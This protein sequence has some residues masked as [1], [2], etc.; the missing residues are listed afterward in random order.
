MLKFVQPSIM[1]N[2]TCYL[3]GELG[4][5]ARVST[6]TLAW[7]PTLSLRGPMLAPVFSDGSENG[8]W[9][10]VCNKSFDI[11]A[12]TSR[13]DRTNTP[14]SRHSFCTSLEGIVLTSPV[15][16]LRLIMALERRLVV[17]SEAKRNKAQAW[18]LSMVAT[19][20]TDGTPPVEVTP[21]R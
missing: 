15:T 17:L 11:T 7:L 2:P 13:R 16:G 9:L 8:A 20:H 12:C 5:P 4:G 18:S 21:P 3:L 14:L 10:S 1:H 19:F 6:A